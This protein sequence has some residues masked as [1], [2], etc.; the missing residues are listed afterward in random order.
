MTRRPNEEYL[1]PSG[2]FLIIINN[3]FLRSINKET[4]FQFTNILMLT[5]A[6]FQ[7]SAILIKK[8]DKKFLKILN[9]FS[10][11]PNEDESYITVFL[12][13]Y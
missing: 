7:S 12:I 9:N 13:S 4:P 3:V 6:I 11:N 5:K 2:E 1:K 8:M 10:V